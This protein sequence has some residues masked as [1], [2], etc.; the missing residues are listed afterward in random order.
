[1]TG[2]MWVTP[3]PMSTTNPVIFP[4]CDNGPCHNT[5]HCQA[6]T[7]ACTLLHMT[8]GQDSA[9]HPAL[10]IEKSRVSCLALRDCQRSRWKATDL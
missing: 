1:M 3:S 7:P 9:Y 10:L 6:L 5:Y 8:G 4:A 2:M